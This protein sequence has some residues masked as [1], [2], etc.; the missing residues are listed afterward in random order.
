MSDQPPDL[1]RLK[2][3]LHNINDWK[4]EFLKEFAIMSYR[5]DELEKARSAYATKDQLEA[6]IQNLETIITGFGK[7][8][9]LKISHLS[10]DIEPLKRALYWGIVTVVGAVILAGMGFL[11]KKP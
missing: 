2:E 3:R 5:V 6:A 11:L 7:E 4:Q 1:S 8:V 9:A 10:N